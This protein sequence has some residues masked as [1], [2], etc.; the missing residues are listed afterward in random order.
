M[1][2]VW[3]LRR[4]GF[5]YNKNIIIFIRDDGKMDEAFEKIELIQ[6]WDVVWVM[7]ISEFSIWVT[8][9]SLLFDVVSVNY[10]YRYRIR[11][12]SL[13]KN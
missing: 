12:H 5:L 2:R 7:V 1:S 10:G 8:A 6:I 13:G 9:V 3:F 4:D 11:V